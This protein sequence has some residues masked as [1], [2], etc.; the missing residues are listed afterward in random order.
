[1]KR[2]NP[3]LPNGYGSIK[4]LGK[5]RTNPYAVFAPSTENNI[6]GKPVYKKPIAYTDTW[7]KAFSILVMYHAGNYKKGDFVPD[8][9]PSD[10]K[11][12]MLQDIVNKIIKTLAPEKVSTGEITFAEVYE[13]FFEYKYNQTK[14][15]YSK[16]SRFNTV[17]AFKNCSVLH[18][19]PFIDLKYNDL[20]KVVDDC[21]LKHSSKSSIV[22]LIKQ[23]FKYA[24][25][26]EIVDKDYSQYVAVKE[27]DDNEQGVPF[28]DNELKI[29]WD[30]KT[31]PICEMLLIMCYSGFRI[32]EYNILEVDYDIKYLKGGIKTTASKNRIVPIH[33]VIYPLIKG[34]LDRQNG[35]FLDTSNCTFR[36]LM[37]KKLEQ[38]KISFHTPHDCRHTFSKLCD[39]YDVNF[40]DKKRMLGH[41]FTDITNKV[42]GHSDLEKLRFEIE[43]IK[44]DF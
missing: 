15:E 29:L 44:V 42:Y 14:K 10:V 30:N 37:Y 26:T 23:M 31:D 7:N 21:A 11:G 9:M 33:S 43:K 13:R 27:K 2:K 40:I 34:R 36:T 16:S 20:Q 32:S 38:L 35:V 41:S 19:R 6:Q 17:A 18:N 8:V 3:R 1:M 5:G 24:M 22:L 28:S 4:Y 12:I 39:K 25:I